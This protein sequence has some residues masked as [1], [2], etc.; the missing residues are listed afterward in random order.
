MNSK[1]KFGHF[2]RPQLVAPSVSLRQYVRGDYRLFFGLQFVLRQ[3]A[4]DSPHLMQQFLSPITCPC[5]LIGFDI[6]TFSLSTLA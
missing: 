6:S 4:A 5:F 3:T 1:S 2:K